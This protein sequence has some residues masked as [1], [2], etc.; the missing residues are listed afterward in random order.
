M[1]NE[2]PRICPFGCLFVYCDGNCVNC[3]SME[4]KNGKTRNRRN[5][6]YDGSEPKG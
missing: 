5:S 6:V 2:E 4:V 1:E 3:D